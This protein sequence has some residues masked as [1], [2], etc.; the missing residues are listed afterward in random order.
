MHNLL[1]NMG[2][3]RMGKPLEAWLRRDQEFV[4]SSEQYHRVLELLEEELNTSQGRTELVMRL[5]A[6]V[7]EYSGHYG[8]VAYILGFHD[9]LEIGTEHGQWYGEKTDFK[10]VDMG[11][12]TGPLSTD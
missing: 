9:G 8:H 10:R 6:A 3:E 7:G 4:E 5:D 11:E 12:Q 1:K 2:M